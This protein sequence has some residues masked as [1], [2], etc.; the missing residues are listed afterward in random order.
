MRS[1]SLKETKQN[2]T[3]AGVTQIH[4]IVVESLDQVVHQ[5]TPSTQK[6]PPSIL[7]Y[8]FK[9]VYYSDNAICTYSEVIQKEVT[10]WPSPMG[11]QNHFEHILYTYKNKYTQI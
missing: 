2:S 5:S 9:Y 8:G 3:V 1:L 4:K 7:D 11:L 10:T 6:N